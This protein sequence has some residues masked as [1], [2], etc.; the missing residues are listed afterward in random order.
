M[1][2]AIVWHSE[3]DRAAKVRSD[4]A[5]RAAADM[6]RQFDTTVDGL[7][8]IQTFFA[9]SQ[10][11]TGREFDQFAGNLLPD[12][13]VG[14][15]LLVQ[16]VP[17]P[18]RQSFERSPGSR[19]IRERVG[20]RLRRAPARDD[21]FPVSYRYTR[22][23]RE[24]PIG[25][26]LA[27][28]P[29]TSQ[30]LTLAR[31]TGRPQATEPV[32]LPE[33]GHPG[34]ILFL[35]IYRRARRVST[36]A[37]RRDATKALVA[38]SFEARQLGLDVQALRPEGT[39]IQILDGG[40]RIFGPAGSLDDAVDRP[41]DAAG[42]SW[43]LRVQTPVHA[44]VALPLLIL[45]G[46]LVL[47]ALVGALLLAL[48][49]RQKRTEG[50][51]H[52]AEERFRRAFEDSGVGM[53]L[54]GV[55]DGRMLDVN[56]ALCALTGRS[57]RDLLAGRIADLLP[58]EDAAVPVSAGRS[59]ESGQDQALVQSEQRL[60]GPGGDPVWVLLSASVVRDADGRP[61]H[62]LVQLQDVSE[63]KD[64]ERQ[65]KHLADHDPL[66]DLF[67]RRGFDAALSRELSA[68]ERYDRA[69]AVISLDLDHF[70]YTNDSLGHS[71]GDELIRRAGSVLSE[72]LRDSDTL[73]RLGG[74]EFAVILPEADQAEAERVAADLLDALRK[75]ATVTGAHGRTGTTASAGIALFGGGVGPVSAEELLAEADIAMYD[76]KEAGRDSAVVFA[77]E[78]RDAQMAGRLEWVERIRHALAEDLFVLHGQEILSLNGD[79][80]P[81]EELLLRMVAEDGSLIA[82]GNFLHL[83]ERFD[84]IQ[85]I[86]R[87]VVRRAIDLLAELERAGRPT[88]LEVNLS[89]KSLTD[90]ELPA[91]IAGWLDEAGVDPAGLV[92]E[93]TETAAIVNVERAKDFAV[94]VRELGCE[95]AIDD[96]GAGFASFYYLKHLAF[97]YLKIDGEFI[98]DLPGNA[99][100]QLLV[101]ALVEI[102]RGLGKHTIAEF[103]TDQATLDLLR[104]LDVDYAQGF[105]VAR[106]RPIDVAGARSPAA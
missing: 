66:T 86:D 101:R 27:A 44:S 75:E 89:A 26:D 12:S 15:T 8:T 95:F 63:R 48:G 68:A 61:T 43:I 4:V 55:D 78:G 18:L 106:P 79:A 45:L 19:P 60:T 81:R 100:N 11:V 21:Y 98:Q 69:G 70:K 104:T 53:A 41:V 6:R 103:V 93:M 16:R 20:G 46:G 58:P 24:L 38:S 49:R 96:F 28:D 90:P 13:P 5:D 17:G 34:M 9:S 7:A 40:R 1:A 37:E 42:R 39:R 23:G 71:V 22:L 59:L 35:P 80:R 97:D 50:D 32:T 54:V 52:A 51:R 87:W 73:A 105:H 64:V 84:L 82:P 92:F 94:S 29:V 72:R 83:A 62:R 33:S 31:E 74:D 14:T 85:E 2:A 10:K 65:L 30:A 77:V 99:T 25:L 67:N 102:A 88:V 91:A 56:D 36:V 76:A 47:S 3:Q 57:R